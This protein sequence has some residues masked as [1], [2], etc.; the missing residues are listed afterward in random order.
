MSSR[1]RWAAAFGA[2]VLSVTALTP[3]QVSA[4]AEPEVQIPDGE[5]ALVRFRMPD[6]ATLQRLVAGGADLAARARSGEADLVVDDAELATLKRAG[7]VPVQLIQQQT[8]A[9]AR[10]ATR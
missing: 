10:K 6:E 7:A 1:T 8:T 2:L 4:A 9:R 3:P 5:H